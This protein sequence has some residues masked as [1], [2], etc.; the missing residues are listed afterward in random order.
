MLTSE[1]IVEPIIFTLELTLEAKIEDDEIKLQFGD[2]ETIMKNGDIKKVQFRIGFSDEQ[3]RIKLIELSGFNPNPSTEI[4]IKKLVINGYEVRDFRPL[5]SFD[6]IDNLFVENKKME[7]TDRVCFNGVLNL[8][9][10]KHRDRFTWFPNTYS[11]QRSGIVFKNGILNCQSQYGCFPEL[12][13]HHDPEWKKFD[14]T[15]PLDGVIPDIVVFGCSFT[16]G[17]G[18]EKNRSWPRL[19]ELNYGKRVL[20]LSV[21]GGGCDSILN[22]I[23]HLIKRNIKMK[24]VIILFPDE[25]RR[26]YRF[27]KHDYFFNFPFL[28]GHAIKNIEPIDAGKFSIFFEKDEL[29]TYAREKSKELVL[30]YNPSRD[31]KIIK[32]ITKILHSNGVEFHLSSWSKSTYQFLESFLNGVNL[33]PMFNE[34]GDKTVGIDNEHPAE[35]IHEEWVKSI[36]KKIGV[37]KK[38]A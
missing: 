1:K 18:I 32:R 37:S 3:D 21:P 29:N 13:C 23:N 24:K 25:G 22:N 6:M 10:Q 2:K 16:A 38:I 17:S 14:L 12:G 11:K 20:N 28:V 31:H 9:T 8:E 15:S 30:K 4:V 26:L 7:V 35:H 33:L 5:L 36:E 19:L 27:R 34:K